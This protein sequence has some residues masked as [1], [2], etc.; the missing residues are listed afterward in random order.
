M[1]IKIIAPPEK[2]CSMLIGEFIQGSL[3]TSWTNV[4]I[5]AR[6]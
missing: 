2:K 6:I 4:D 3:S 1:R 5:K